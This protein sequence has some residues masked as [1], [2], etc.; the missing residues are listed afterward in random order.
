MTLDA[1][2]IALKAE[3]ERVV[4]LEAT[5]IEL[6]NREFTWYRVSD[7]DRLLDAAVTDASTP[8]EEIDPFW[9]ATWRAALG[10]DQF[11][12]TLGIE[13]QRVLELGCG[14]GQAGVGAAARG[15]EVTMTDAVQ[16]ALQVARL[17]AQPVV[18][19]I[20]FQQLKWN[21]PPLETP[22]FPIIIGSDLVYDTSLFPALESCARAHLATNGRLYLS[23]PH[24][25][26]GRCTN[27][28]S[29]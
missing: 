25:H 22:A 12:G 17:N 23:E 10:L 11:L 29:T 3:I 19:Q 1:D 5:T 2:W 20:R 28:I 9:A 13:G 7:P 21:D 15:A 6:G 18:G 24:R 8:A 26:T 16:L 4:P 27:T 14:S